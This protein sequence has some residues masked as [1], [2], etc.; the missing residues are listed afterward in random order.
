MQIRNVPV[1]EL[2][3]IAREVGVEPVS[4]YLGICLRPKGEQYR[5]RKTHSFFGTT[6]RINAV[7][8]HGHKAFYDKLYTE[9]PQAKVR[10]AVARFDGVEDYRAKVMGVPHFQPGYSCACPSEHHVQFGT[11]HPDGS[12]TGVRF[13]KQADMQRC[14]FFIIGAEH[15]RDDGSCRCDDAEH[16]KMMIREWKYKARDFDGIPLR[17]A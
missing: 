11:L 13:I 17:T 2:E 6:R 12:M 10:T 14:P 4:A 15:Y 9:Y 7:C 1:E 16:R 3:R 5:V 8:W